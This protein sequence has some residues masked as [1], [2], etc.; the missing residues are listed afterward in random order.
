MA[1]GAV[2][3]AE[4]AKRIEEKLGIV[5]EKKRTWFE[6]KGVD[7]G[8]REEFSKRRKQVEKELEKT[9]N[10]GA[11]AS[12]IATLNTREVKKHVARQELF[13]D[14][15]KVGKE[16]G[17]GKDELAKITNQEPIKRNIKVEKAEAFS[18]SIEKITAH[19]N[20]FS[21][22]DLIRNVAEQAQGRGLGAKE[23][24]STVDE[25]LANNKEIIELGRLEKGAK[26]DNELRYTTKEML[27]LEGSMLK[28]V[29]NSKNKSSISVSNSSINK[30]FKN[31]K[32]IS[33]EQK[34][35]VIHITQG[36][37]SVKAV[38]GMAGTGKS[39]ML[40]AVKEAY[41]LEGK[42]VIGA[43]LSGKAAQG[44][45]QGSGIKSDTIHK[46]LFDID[47]GNLC[48]NSSTVLVVDEAGMVGTRQMEK[49]VTHTQKAG[50]KLVLVGDA[51][52]LQPVDAGGAFKAISS[53]IGEVRL[54]EIRRQDEAWARG[55]VHK[56]A[57]GN[58]K[59][60]LAE[61]AKR[62]QLHVLDNQKEAKEN[63]IKNWKDSGGVTKPSEHLILVGTNLEARDLNE[64][65]QM[66]RFSAK[67]LSEDS[68][69]IGAGQRGFSG[70]RVL[71]TKNSR[72]LGLRNGQLGTI[73]RVDT[74][75]NRLKAK[76]DNGKSVNISLSEY[77]HIKLGYA[78]TTH[79]S[80]GMTAKN[81]YILVGGA[82]QDKEMSYVQVSR[83]KGKTQIFTDKTE[84]GEN[85]TAL[86]RKMGKSRQ[87]DLA[88][89]LLEKGDLL[90]INK[91][92]HIQR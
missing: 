59:E 84:A 11:V 41:E 83:A 65:A 61:F 58:A 47:K 63:L 80:Q 39:Y 87:K 3:R 38:S 2:Y 6:L 40:G 90:A 67:E 79:K 8:L 75:T 7:K 14:W 31:R 30:A 88:S 26:K 53:E 4:L 17:W 54:S 32:S 92:M 89:D 21:R 10:S 57:N 44:L 35:A 1:A 68:I 36:A 64:K 66:A 16:H 20:H 48:L 55:V 5:A 28:K 37:G 52:Q 70:D 85:L 71:F 76:L 50:A 45:E 19:Q 81:T 78:V 51:R 60:G 91:A 77:E 22:R 23:I 46:T 18:S 62:G 15:K 9:G 72:A 29:K 86:L 24:F 12:K 13:K 25:N 73:E 49:L 56:F 69:S 33:E 34:N 42:K 74:A 82:M 43:A 27:E